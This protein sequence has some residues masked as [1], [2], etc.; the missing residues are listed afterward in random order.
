MNLVKP[1]LTTKIV[2]ALENNEIPWHR[3][4]IMGTPRNFVTHKKYSGANI[5]LLLLS[6]KEN[7]FTNHL[8]GTAAEFG[9]APPGS[10]TQ[11]ISGEVYNAQQF[12]KPTRMANV[13]YT[14][15]NKVLHAV[16]AKVIYNNELKAFYEFPPSD[17]ISI[18]PFKDFE[19]TMPGPDGYFETLAHELIHWTEPRLGFDYDGYQ[20][21]E[22]L[23]E[24]RAELG[25]AF[26]M[27][28]LK[29]PNSIFYRNFVDFRE[30]WIKMIKKNPSIIFKIADSAAQAVDCILAHSR[31]KE[32]RHI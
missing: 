4:G 6:A 17:Y 10:A 7:D 23:R 21:P 18:P 25:A 16:P 31:L 5:L 24:L 3:K 2:A 29:I 14:L 11:I 9:N 8:W 28:E 1:S 19:D 26:L 12:S 15:A 20:K 22:M 27:M 30:K 13:D 32:V